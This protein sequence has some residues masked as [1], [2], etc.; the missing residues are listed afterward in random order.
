MLDA[1]GFFVGAV[2]GQDYSPFR[3][4]ASEGLGI[5]EIRFTYLI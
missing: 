1:D 5:W 3:I 4:L 2:P